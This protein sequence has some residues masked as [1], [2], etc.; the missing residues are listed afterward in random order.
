MHFV[1]HH[2]NFGCTDEGRIITK[3]CCF[4]MVIYSFYLLPLSLSE[5]GLATVVQHW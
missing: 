3:M 4:L 5:L 1:C 2:A